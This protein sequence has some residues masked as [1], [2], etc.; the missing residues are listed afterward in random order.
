MWK[1]EKTFDRMT[2]AGPNGRWE[3]HEV[4]VWDVINEET[5]MSFECSSEEDAAF[6]VGVLSERNNA[7]SEIKKEIE[8]LDDYVDSK[9]LNK[10]QHLLKRIEDGEAAKTEAISLL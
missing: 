9:K 2:D 1:V 10:L 5:G 8:G 4:Y 7:S 6:L 3:Q